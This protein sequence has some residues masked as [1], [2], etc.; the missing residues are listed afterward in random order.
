MNICC[1]RISENWGVGR[2]GSVGFRNDDDDNPCFLH[3]A[4]E[5]FETIQGWFVSM[6]FLGINGTMSMNEYF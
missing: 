3:V 1:V 4:F 5:N 2:G 6:R